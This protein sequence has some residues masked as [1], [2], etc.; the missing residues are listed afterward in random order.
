MDFGLALL[1][2]AIGVAVWIFQREF[3]RVRRLL[4]GSFSKGRAGENLLAAA[5]GEFPPEL[6][7]RDVRIGGR[8]C[9]FA[10]Q[11]TDHRVLPIDSKWPG[12]E[13]TDD[14]ARKKV[15]EV[16]RY[17]DPAVTTPMAVMAVPDS[18]YSSCRKAHAEALAL[19]VIIVSYTNA[20]PVLLTLF[21]LHQAYGGN[22][23]D[24]RAA[25]YLQQLTSGLA[26]MQRELDGRLANSFKQLDNSR[27]ALG[28]LVSSARAC[29]SAMRS[30]DDAAA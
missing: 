26:A 17:I 28:S 3:S 24:Q 20:V 2:I 23:A 6:L 18:V 1:A 15:R 8:I 4:T 13:G 11:V 27:I 30:T 9:E 14:A 16:A 21:A 10:L 25:V 22:A 29:M 5:L 12:S 19:R 7:K